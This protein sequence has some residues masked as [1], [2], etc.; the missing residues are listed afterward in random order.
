M[1]RITLGYFLLQTTL[2][3][4]GFI[5]LRDWVFPLLAVVNLV[6]GPSAL[7]IFALRKN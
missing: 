7:L 6:S 4:L 3:S 2:L 1:I 5:F